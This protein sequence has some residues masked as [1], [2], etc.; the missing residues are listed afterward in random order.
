[1]LH[2]ETGK[3]KLL[4]DLLLLLLLPELLPG[5][6]VSDVGA[7]LGSFDFVQGECDR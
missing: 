5:H 3:G 6:L 4:S 1:M 2:P 7:I